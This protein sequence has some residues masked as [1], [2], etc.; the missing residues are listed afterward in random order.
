MKTT[1]LNTFAKGGAGVAAYRF[2]EALISYENIQSELLF[3]HGKPNNR[4]KNTTVLANNFF[5]KN[6]ALAMLAWEKLLFSH[7]LKD[8]KDRFRYSIATKGVGINF[9]KQ[10]N[11]TDIIHLHWI[12]NG[13]LS[14]KNLKELQ[15]LNKPI[16]ITLHDMW[17]MTGGCHHSRECTNFHQK[18][19]NCFYLKSPSP[20][21]VSAKVHQQKKE[22]YD[23][24]N[25]VFTVPST[26]MYDI[27]KKSSL[28]GNRR[29]EVVANPLDVEVYKPAD[30]PTAKNNFD[31]DEE[32]ICIGFVAA[33][34]GNERKGFEYLRKGLWKLSEKNLEWEKRVKLLLMG[35]AKTDVKLD[36]PFEY[37]LT[38]YLNDE[39]QIVNF[40]NACDVFVSPSLEESLGYTIM[41]A[42]SCG[43]PAVT[44]NTSGIPDMVEHRTNGYLANYLDV[45]DLA[46]G[47]IETIESILKEET[48]QKNARQKIVKQFDYKKIAPKME[49]IYKSLV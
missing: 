41:E 45:D 46:N 31:I 2:H 33:D 22:L 15:H 10:L 16:V 34:I 14:L 25:V 42:L 39:K 38:G 36:V 5:K 40:Y 23:G 21:D 6:Y 18:C 48:L 28:L 49:A 3:L 12:N 26:W 13:F 29:V 30:K 27:A 24:L 17:Y 43:V 9:I 37:V 19:G 1:H 44:F 11:T 47:L 32:T 35:E 8:Q 4:F 7:Q 20:N